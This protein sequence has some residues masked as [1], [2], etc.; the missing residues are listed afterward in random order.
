MQGMFLKRLKP[1][2]P[3]N[4]LLGLAGLMWSAVGAMLCWLAYDWLTGIHWTRT[5][6]VGVA[7]LVLALAVYRFGFSKIAKRNIERI[8]CGPESACLF[9][10]QAWRG[11]LTIGL[12]VTIGSVLRSA[13]FPKSYLAIPY[14]AIGGRAPPGKSPLLWS[15]LADRPFSSIS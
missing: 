12:M 15:P 5:V 9:S 3:K 10:F 14:A 11:Y 1:S 8:R 6:A 2:V 7:G 4:C 13:P